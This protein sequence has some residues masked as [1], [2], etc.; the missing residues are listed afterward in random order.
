MR[1]QFKERLRLLSCWSSFTAEN[2]F[3]QFTNLRKLDDY[4]NSFALHLPEVYEQTFSAERY[5]VTFIENQSASALIYLIIDLQHMCR[6]HIS[7]VHFALE[8]AAEESSW[9]GA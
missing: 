8:W 3:S 7:F 9:E 5:A 1:Q 2:A 4:L 6:N